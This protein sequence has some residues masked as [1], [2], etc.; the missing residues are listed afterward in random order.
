MSNDILNL[1]C[2]QLR[3]SIA[4]GSIKSADAVI[5]SKAENLLAAHARISNADVAAE[6]ASLASGEVLFK[7]ATAAQAHSNTIQK[8][9]QILLK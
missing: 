6:V 5:D 1:T 8:L 7:A 4:A 9:A 3:D 2:L